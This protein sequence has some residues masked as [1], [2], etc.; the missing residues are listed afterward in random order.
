MKKQQRSKLIEKKEST[1][2]LI[3]NEMKKIKK[4]KL[5]KKV[6]AILLTVLCIGFYLKIQGKVTTFVL[7]HHNNYIFRLYRNESC[8]CRLG[9]T[10]FS[11][12]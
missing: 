3:A 2:D 5:L 10:Q 7:F 11:N 1:H 6:K 12:M 9:I 4:S 8:S